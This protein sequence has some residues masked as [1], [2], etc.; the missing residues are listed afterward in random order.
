MTDKRTLRAR[1]RAERDAFGAD[2]PPLTPPQP[3]LDRLCAGLTVATYHP[4]GG[5][6]DPALFD[7]AVLGAA[8]ELALPHVIDRATPIRFLHWPRNSALVPGPY[9]LRQPPPGAADVAPD[10]ILTPLVGFDRQGDRLGQGAG[11]YDRAFAQHPSA[12]RI[13]LAWSVQEVDRLTPDPWDVPL[14]AVVTE[15]E[16]IVP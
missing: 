16:W 6:P 3:F 1:L 13:G 14:H 7:A 8:G 5:E 2:R 4:V 15:K 9:T 12:W 11:H 10:I